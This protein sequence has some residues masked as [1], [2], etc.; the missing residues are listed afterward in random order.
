M[1]KAPTGLFR[2]RPSLPIPRRSSSLAHPHC[3]QCLRP[4]GATAAPFAGHNK[5]SKTKHIKAV[6]DKKKMAERA[7]FTQLI[8]M[9]SRMYGED[10][11]FNTQMANAIAAATKANVPKHLIEAAIAKGQGRSATGA[12]LEN[13]TIEILFPPNVALIVDVETDNKLRSLSDL[14]LV[15]KKNGGVVGS[16]TF[17]FSRRGRII[18]NPK[19]D[20]TTLSD[21]LEKAIELDGTEDVEEL[22]E[23]GFQVW[24]QPAALMATTKALAGS[25]D[26]EVQESEIIWAPNQDTTVAVESPNVVESLDTLLSKLREFQ[27][28]KAVFANIR[29]GSINGEEW[30]RVVRHIDL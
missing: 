18:L 3:L 14:K 19:A 29:Q 6:T 27:E 21:V 30:D 5:W 23:G 10:I 22:P 12:R 4:F 15:V 2:W 7:N 25:L 17:Y 26:V 1:S 8:A 16:T 9:Y 11:K 13:L 24:T 28:V 20:A